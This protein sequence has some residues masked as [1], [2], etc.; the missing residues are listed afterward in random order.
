MEKKNEMVAHF[1]VEIFSLLVLF[2]SNLFIL[3]S[4]MLLFIWHP[5]LFSYQKPFKNL[6]SV[7]VHLFALYFTYF[8]SLVSGMALNNPRTFRY[9]FCSI[10]HCLL[11]FR[12]IILSHYYCN[13]P[14]FTFVYF[15]FFHNLI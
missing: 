5:N 1:G 2:S 12:T 15:N 7:F 14:S 6:Q 9:I 8:I 4:T 13:F 3:L 10:M 11:E